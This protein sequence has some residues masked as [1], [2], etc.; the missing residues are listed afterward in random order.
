MSL[1]RHHI[2]AI[3]GALRHL[4]KAPGSFFLNVLV[5][6][7]ALTLPFTGL[8]ILQNMKPVANQVSVQPEVSVFL[9]LNT[10]PDRAQNFTSAIQTALKHQH[11]VGTVTYISRDTALENLKRKTGLD[12]VLSTLGSN[13]LPDSYVITL[14]NQGDADP[15]NVIGKLT[16]ELQSMPEVDVVQL[17]SEWI[18]RLS[19]LLHILH[20]ALFF[21][22]IALSTVVIAVVFNTIRLQVMT[23]YDEIEVSSLFGATNSFIHRP[24]YYTGALLGLSAGILAFAFVALALLPLNTAISD[25]AHLYASEFALS[26]PDTTTTLLLL[27][28]SAALGLIGAKLSVRKHLAKLK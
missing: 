6:A 7:I 11:L 14:N 2:F 4:R 12:N 20:V 9:K 28:A 22:A 13:P 8:T 18:K 23:Q 10:S 3:Q 21:L 5:V 1:L 26:L 19:A 15:S 27:F 25:F 16:D 24:F 17:D